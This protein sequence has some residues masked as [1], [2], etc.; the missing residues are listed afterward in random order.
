MVQVKDIRRVVRAPALQV[1][2][3]MTLERYI[4]SFN[5]NSFDL[6]DDENNTS[7]ALRTEE[8]I[9]EAHRI[10][11]APSRLLRNGSC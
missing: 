2:S 7:H 1:A 3:W 6:Q 9:C 5:L 10:L 11:L 4:T 8:G